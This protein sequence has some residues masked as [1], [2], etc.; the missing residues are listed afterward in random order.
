MRSI[1]CIGTP[2]DR[3]LSALRK[4]GAVEWVSAGEE[5]DVEVFHRSYTCV[6]IASDVTAA[7]RRRIVTGLAPEWSSTVVLL[8]DERSHEEDQCCRTAEH[9]PVVSAALSLDD[10]AGGQVFI[11]G[12]VAAS[13][14]AESVF[15][16]MSL[17]PVYCGTNAEHARLISWIE[18]ALCG[19]SRMVVIEAVSM[20]LRV[21]LPIDLAASVIGRSSAHS[22]QA[23]KF[24]DELLK[25]EGS[26]ARQPVPVATMLGNLV[27]IARPLGLPLPLASSTMN[28]LSLRL[29]RSADDE[30]CVI[31]PFSNYERMVGL[32]R[33]RVV[34]GA[35]HDC[36]RDDPPPPP[37]IGYVGLGAMGSALAM[38]ALQV[39][40]ELHVF[41]PD[42]AKVER[43]TEKGAHA[44]ADVASLAAVCDLVF[45][46]VPSAKEVEQI[47][48]GPDGMYGALPHGAIVIDQTTC[49]P[50][51]TVRFGERLAAAGVAMVDAPVTGGPNGVRNGTL[52]TMC[53]G[54]RAAFSHVRPV[55]EAM[56]GEVVYFGPPGSG[57]AI[58]LVKNAL[59]AANRLMIYEALSLATAFG[60]PIETLRAALSTGP[61][62]SRALDRIATSIATGAPTADASLGT[63]VKDQQL[64]ACMGRITSTPLPLL[65]IART[66]L[67]SGSRILGPQA[68]VDELGRLYGIESIKESRNHE[69]T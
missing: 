52:V 1:A 24:F 5:Q 69:K 16:R 36:A 42:V 17:R 60:I 3:W 66:V 27:D 18:H 62:A 10:E 30:Q 50:A 57:Q 51:D 67:E 20:A 7:A 34:T 28:L 59:A 25:R 43:L 6:L 29:Q 37:V 40:R 68:E 49:S 21:R 4:Q 44:A 19:I 35:L 8:I 23:E 46:C 65:N 55:L 31:D 33:D 12:D 64:I 47:L 9:V 53:G 41:D 22:R 56:G 2:S 58:K 45:L 15:G 39:G 14:R 63:V 61:S 38:Q 26:E 32:Q 54:T 48:F 11:S 13:E